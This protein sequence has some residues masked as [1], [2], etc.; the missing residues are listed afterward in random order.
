MLSTDVCNFFIKLAHF[1]RDQSYKKDVLSRLMGVISLPNRWSA[2]VFSHRFALSIRARSAMSARPITF[3][4][5]NSLI[6]VVACIII[7]LTLEICMGRY[8]SIGR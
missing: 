5:N 6:F 8:S 3:A 1:V 7:R 2:R 4:G